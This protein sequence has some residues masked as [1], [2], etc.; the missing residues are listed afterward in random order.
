M[1]SPE[2]DGA[3]DLPLRSLAVQR[4]LA[5]RQAVY[6]DEV[7]RL[8]DAGL[9]VMR[10]TGTA[11]TPRVA[12]IVRQAGLS[13]QAFYRHFAGKED[14]VA[15]IVEAGMHRLAG[16]L[17]HQ[18]GKDDSPEDQIRRWVEGIMSQAAN[19]EVAHST[20]AVLWNRG[21]LGDHNRESNVLSN[22]VFAEL[23]VEPLARFGSRDPRRD[24]SVIC[25]AAMGRMN[26][27]LWRPLRPQPADTAHLVRFCLA[28][29]D[30]GADS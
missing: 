17:R 18:I 13:N 28:A 7:Q 30:R 6:A 3:V 21:H 4:A 22:E 26:E 25:H 12:D 2:I 15:A 23:L 29:V 14:L 8:L 16:Y 5:K 10:R 19:S 11:E 24:A 27:F 20:R 9:E 1:S